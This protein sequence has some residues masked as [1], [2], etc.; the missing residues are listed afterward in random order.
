MTQNYREGDR[1]KFLARGRL[2]IGTITRIR[3]KRRRGRARQLAELVTGDASSL[4]STV[5]EIVPDGERG[6]WTVG[7]GSIQQR[8][9]AAAPAERQAAY[10]TVQGIKRSHREHRSKVNGANYDALHASGL[11]EVFSGPR[12]G[13]GTEIEVK[14][15]DIGWAPA[16]FIGLVAGSFNVRYLRHGRTRTTAAANVRLAVQR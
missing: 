11:W 5:A 8:I 15:S 10:A 3:E 6:A 9:A 13:E 14:F 16:E 4:D 12:S 2:K 1:V 7:I